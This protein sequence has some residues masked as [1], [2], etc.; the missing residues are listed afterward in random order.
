VRRVQDEVIGKRQQPP[1]ERAV[2][3]ASHLLDGVLPVGVEVR[4]AGVAD[5][6]RVAGE[7]EP[8]LLAARV[9]GDE[10]GVVG[11]R[12]PRGRDRGDRGV[13]ERHELA[14]AQRVVVE[15]DARAFRE[16]RDGA[17][18]RDQLGQPGD[19]VG[20]DVGVEDG[21]DRGALSLRQ[22]DVLIDEVDVRS[23]T[24]NALCV[25]HPNR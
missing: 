22:G 10:V 3:R 13:A 20:L 18:A 12:V 4:A 2:E 7:H 21:G 25:L 24:A 16:V 8:R 23:T 1:G 19:V 5:K 14:V 15:L 11:E 17:G 6:Q 9:V